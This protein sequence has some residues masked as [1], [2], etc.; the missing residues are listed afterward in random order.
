M[1]IDDRRAIAAITELAT[2]YDELAAALE[3]ARLIRKRHPI[4]DVR[5]QQGMAVERHCGSS[6]RAHDDYRKLC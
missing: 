5:N 1:G 4:G 3:R 6:R 2:Q